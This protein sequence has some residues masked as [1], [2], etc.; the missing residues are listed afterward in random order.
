L[1]V[2][3]YFLCLI[4]SVAYPSWHCH[5]LEVWSYGE[6]GTD[7]VGQN[8]LLVWRAPEKTMVVLQCQMECASEANIIFK[9]CIPPILLVDWITCMD[10]IYV[11]WTIALIYCSYQNDTSIV[12]EPI[13][14]SELFQLWYLLN[15]IIILSQSKYILWLTYDNSTS[16]YSN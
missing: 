15:L 8:F 14:W 10:D 16:S 4:F 2:S 7:G 13:S 3:T 1:F 9:Y 5:S 12:T 11:A 6:Q